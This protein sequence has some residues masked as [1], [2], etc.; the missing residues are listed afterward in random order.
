MVLLFSSYAYKN[1]MK[2]LIFLIPLAV[3]ALNATPWALYKNTVNYSLDGQLYHLSPSSWKQLNISIPKANQ[4][5][6]NTTIIVNRGGTP[7][8]VVP[9]SQGARFYGFPV[10]FYLKKTDVTTSTLPGTRAVVTAFSWMWA[11]LDGLLVIITV[12]ICLW[13]NYRRSSFLPYSS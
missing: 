12:A 1:P 4:S 3:L 6:Y 5:I 9:L 11:T 2:K 7:P 10:G 13:I 8:L